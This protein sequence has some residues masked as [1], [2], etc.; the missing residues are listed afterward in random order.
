[1]EESVAV[2]ANKQSDDEKP[3]APTTTAIAAPTEDNIH[4]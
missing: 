3:E 4:D 1:M 2:I